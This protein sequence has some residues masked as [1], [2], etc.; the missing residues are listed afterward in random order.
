MAP[1]SFGVVAE[2]LLLLCTDSQL[3]WA[4][5]ALASGMYACFVMG[6]CSS[7]AAVWCSTGVLNELT[8]VGVPHVVCFVLVNTIV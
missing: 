6:R 1:L 8:V 2:S 5:S 4:G 7:A 3:M